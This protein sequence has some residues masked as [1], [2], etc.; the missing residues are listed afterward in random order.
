MQQELAG[1]NRRI[2]I[3]DDNASIHADFRKILAGQDP[4]AG[5]LARAEAELFGVALTKPREQPEFELSSAFQ[6]QQALELVRDAV[7]TGRPFAMAFVDVRMPPGWDGIETTARLWEADPD[8][9]I[10]ICTAYSDYSWD[11]MITRL[12]RSDRMVIL[13]KPFDTV[14]VL[15]LANAL[16]E[17]W[18]LSQQVKL[19][20][21]DLERLIEARTRELQASNEQLRKEVQERQMTEQV[22]R[23]IQEKLNHFLA[24]SPA[25]L[26]SF[27]VD[28]G[29]AVPAWV[30]DNFT[31]LTGGTVEDWFRQELELDYVAAEDRAFVR[32]R[33]HALLGQDHLSIQ[34]RVRRQDG[35]VRWVRDDRRVLRDDVGQPVEV[36]GCWTDITD[37][38]LLED[39]LRQSQKMESVGLLAGGIAHDFNNLLMVIRCHVELLQANEKPSE[40]TVE[41]FNRIMAAADR[42]TNLTRQLLA[43]S[44]KQVM[45]MEDL[46]LNAL[47]SALARL[48]GPTLGAQIALETHLGEALP[49]VHVD[50]SM[51]EQ[52]VMNLAVNARDAMP[53]G[54]RLSLTTSIQE[55]TAADQLNHPES[56][57]GRYVCLAISDTGNGIAAAHLPRIFE[58]FFTTKE[59]GKGTG[60][61][62]ATVYGIIKQHQG[63][64]EVESSLGSGTTFRI[65]LPATTQPALAPAS[66]VPVSPAQGGHETILVVE[67]EPALRGLVRTILQ[68]QG[69]KV[70]TAAS[71]VEALQA[72]SQR[73]DQIDL[74][75]TDLVMPEG[76]TGWE[77][78]RQLQTEKPGLK[79]IYMSGYSQE[80]NRPDAVVGRNVRFL[81]KPFGARILMEAV[82]SCLDEKVEPQVG[83]PPVT[84]R[85]I[86][87]SSG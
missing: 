18:K 19:K 3:V 16:T 14:E 83:E 79:A 6:G 55:F 64:A 61:G 50:R 51:I 71:G 8:L 56:R 24:K 69:Y 62:L 58:P 48:L 84:C 76:L 27:R 41:P 22:L 60:L 87:A 52:V 54:G 33:H 21:A 38:R 72:W 10:V 82:R 13:K 46:D 37:Q 59:L 23:G 35:T 30:S 42:A 9:Q 65:Y 28:A 25:V 44:R 74:L 66:P 15:Q 4:D 29:R 1:S 26:F 17:K 75:L 86:T 12:G 77:L 63:W 40:S 68:R 47:T 70:F 73:L 5:G 20:F 43:F 11:E 39:E 7:Q 57:P 49:A 78:A 34:Y 31:K 80:I 36:V 81:A 2:L 67:D 53:K 85:T 45:R 32:E